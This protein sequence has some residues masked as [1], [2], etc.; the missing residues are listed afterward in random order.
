MRSSERSESI[1]ESSEPQQEFVPLREDLEVEVCIVGAGLAGLSTGYQLTRAGRT[2]V[3][4]DDNAVA[5]GETGQTTAHLASAMDDRFTALERM[6]GA[7][8]SR[9]AYES[10]QAAIEEIDR[11]VREEHIDCDLVRLD[12]Y[13][14]LAPGDDPARL[15]EELRAAQRAGFHDAQRLEGVPFRGMESA[16]CIRFPR[17]GRFHPLLFARGLALAVHQRGGH[18]FT[19]S[20]VVEIE[21]G[22]TVAV[23]TSDGHTVRAGAVVVATNSPINTM[24]AI[25]SKQHPYRSYAVAMRVT[26]EIPDALYWDTADPYHY[27]RLQEL[28]GGQALIVGGEDHRTGQQPDRDPYASLIDWTRGRFPVR[29]ELGRWSGQVLEPVDGISY[30]G[31]SPESGDNVYVITGDSGQG[32]TSSTLGGMLVRDLILGLENPWEKLY[33]PSRITLQAESL[34]EYAKGN[35]EVAGHYG[36]WIAGAFTADDAESIPPGSGAVLRRKGKAIAA[37]RDTAGVL[38]ERSAV[39]THLGCIV[40]W[41]AEETSWDCPCHGSRFA[42]DGAVLN[43]PAPYPLEET[44]D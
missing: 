29:E 21:G 13:L 8:G 3:V 14:F 39:C 20:H 1:W 34:A 2:V 7:E 4:L 6:H 25:H 33:D 43:G 42:T 12:G 11:I 37:Y 16:A 9:L 26:G 24:V 15:D 28:P 44:G 30:I 18:I 41:N 31:R 5:G 32:M 40:H 19:G 17:Q 10:H 35:L 23:R 36:E 27:V 38:H 22:P